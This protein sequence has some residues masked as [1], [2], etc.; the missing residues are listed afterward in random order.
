[1]SFL[2][3]CAS[4]LRWTEPLWSIA[5]ESSSQ[6]VR[7]WTHPLLEEICAGLGTRHTAAAAITAASEAIAV[8]IS[9]SSGTV[10]VFHEG[11]EILKLEKTQPAPGAFFQVDE[12]ECEAR[13]NHE[14][15]EAD[16]RLYA[17]V[18]NEE[19]ARACTE[20][21]DDACRVVPG[22]FFRNADQPHVDEDRR[23][24]GFAE[25][26][27]VRLLGSVGAS[28]PFVIAW[29]VPIRESGSLIPQ[30]A[31]GA[32]VRRHPRRAG[33]WVLGSV[34]QGACVASMA[35]VVWQLDGLQAGV[36]VLGLLVAFSLSRASV[37]CPPKTCRES[38]S[39]SRAV[40]A[41][42]DWPRPS[43]DLLRLPSVC[44]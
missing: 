30:L 41:W 11:K 34:L 3:A 18:A 44:Y 37:A 5:A 7:T 36:A 26:R 22:N 39:P 12:V 40:V 19:D 13:S 8:V 17:L 24:P 4:L 6:P 42:P 28:P 33:F 2:K 14:R 29:L 35:L 9:E 21:S 10:T 31:I 20:I 38:A 25:A 1:M 23:S 27:V 16:D 43:R 32:W 15:E